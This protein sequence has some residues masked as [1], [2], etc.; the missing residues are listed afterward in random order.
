MAQSPEEIDWSAVTSA[1]AGRE[2]D[3]LPSG[4][5]PAGAESYPSDEDVA[6]PNLKIKIKKSKGVGQGG[7]PTPTPDNHTDLIYPQGKV[8]LTNKG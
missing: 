7:R 2:A 3:P 5:I 8:V 1:A 4:G 6:T